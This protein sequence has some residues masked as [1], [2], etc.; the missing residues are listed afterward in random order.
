MLSQVT[1]AVRPRDIIEEIWVRDVVDLTW[2]VLR[3]RSFKT[4]LL[5]SSAQTGIEKLLIPL[6]GSGEASNLAKGWYKRE[7]AAQE[8]VHDLLE[9]AG[10]N[11]AAVMAETLSKKLDD[12][13]RIERMLANSEARRNAVLRE[14]D[15]HRAA[16]ADLLR[17]ASERIEDAEFSD[18]SD[19]EKPGL[20]VT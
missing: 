13:E 12:I 9:N 3:L 14:V 8:K 11:M 6:V 1:E 17:A 18:V 16:L 20:A 19:G 7:H 2:D 10:L 15:R 5:R 4:Q